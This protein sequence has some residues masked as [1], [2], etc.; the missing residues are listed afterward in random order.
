MT[1]RKTLIAAAVLV[2][3]APVL[4]ALAHDDEDNKGGG[5]NRFLHQYGIPHSPFATSTMMLMIIKPRAADTVSIGN[6]EF[7][8]MP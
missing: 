5:V 8:F 7:S 1:L 6:T 2:L 3:S 4:P